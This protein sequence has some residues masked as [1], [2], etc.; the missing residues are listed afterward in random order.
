VLTI[1]E[2]KALEW[3]ST[4]LRLDCKLLAPDARQLNAGLPALFG[5]CKRSGRPASEEPQFKKKK[6]PPG[7]GPA[8]GAFKVEFVRSGRLL[9]R[10]PKEHSAQKLAPPPRGSAIPGPGL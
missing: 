7:P 3:A 9:S 4:A 1:E 2:L 6:N 10:P 8:A 5:A